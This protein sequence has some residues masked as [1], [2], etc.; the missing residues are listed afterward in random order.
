MHSGRMVCSDTGDDELCT[1]GLHIKCH[2]QPND[3]QTEETI[4]WMCASP[5]LLKESLQVS[6]MF[7]DKLDEWCPQQMMGLSI[8]FLFAWRIDRGRERQKP[9]CGIEWFASRVWIE[10][11]GPKTLD[12]KASDLECQSVGCPGWSSG[13]TETW[14]LIPFWS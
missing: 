3:V 6:E 1:I 10:E 4:C 5:G 12:S 14:F 11:F 13:L 7:A 8:G 9:T 2:K